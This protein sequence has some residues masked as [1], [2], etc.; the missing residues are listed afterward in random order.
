VRGRLGQLLVRS[1]DLGKE[2][3]NMKYTRPELLIMTTAAVAVQSSS[4]GNFQHL[5]NIMEE[6]YSVP[7]A[8]EADE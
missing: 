8:Y 7:P 5:D 1:E 6:S 4:K 3:T 2:V